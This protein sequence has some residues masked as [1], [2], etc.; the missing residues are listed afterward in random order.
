MFQPNDL[1]EERRLLIATSN[2]SKVREIVAL[3]AGLQI[4][5]RS[6][7]DFTAPLPEPAETGST[8][9][10][11]ALLKADHYYRLTGWTSLADDSGLV[12]DALNGAPGIYSARYAGEGATDEMNLRRLLAALEAIPAERRNARFVCSLALVGERCRETFEGSCEGIIAREPQGTGGFGYDPIFFDPELNCTFAQLTPEQ[13]AAR[14]HRGRALRAARDFLERR[15]GGLR[16]GAAISDA[17]L[18]PES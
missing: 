13:K 17:T 7:D 12:V 2:R 16:N 8:F 9:E 14:S 6:L 11:N 3:L 18:R 4:S 10:E 1:P 5:L 15:A